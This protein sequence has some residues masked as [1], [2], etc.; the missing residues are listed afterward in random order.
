MPCGIKSQNH[1]NYISTED[2]MIEDVDINFNDKEC[3]DLND[4]SG[5]EI[6]ICQGNL[7]SLLAYIKTHTSNVNSNATTLKKYC[8]IMYGPPASGK[9]VGRNIAAHWIKKYMD[10][11]LMSE[12]EIMDTFI[13]TNVDDIVYKLETVDGIEIKKKLTNSS[14]NIINPFND[15]TLT[16]NDKIKIAKKEINEL[17]KQS[18][19]IYFSK[20][21]DA[22]AVS[23]LLCYVA[24]FLGKNIFI[25]I[26][27]GNL[28]YIENHIL[29]FCKWYNYIPCIIYPFVKNI[30]ILCNRMHR[31]ALIDG[32]YIDC[33]DSHYGLRGKMI[34]TF[35]Q[36]NKIKDSIDKKASKYLI[37]MYMADNLDPLI[38]NKIINNNFVGFDD[39]FDPLILEHI[40]KTSD[41]KQ[42]YFKTCDY[43]T[44]TKFNMNLVNTL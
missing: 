8:V 14:N 1:D 17:V 34:S 36:W 12:N 18:S 30:D 35:N 9:T 44:L 21:T 24:A 4:Q 20:R 13:D 29:D 38:Y 2:E 41:K 16:D 5:R 26:S 39:Y 11:T 33:D 31:R 7:D 23:Q 43:E 15:S 6:K 19:T 10:D 3:I 37:L 25:E 32:R 40:D 27:S 42:S 22:D 28:D